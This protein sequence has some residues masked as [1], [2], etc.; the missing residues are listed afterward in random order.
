MYLIPERYCYV[1]FYELG[2]NGKTKNNWS[3]IGERSEK[4]MQFWNII[5]DRR[6]TVWFE[7]VEQIL[8]ECFFSS[9]PININDGWQLFNGC[10]QYRRCATNQPIVILMS[11][12]NGTRKNYIYNDT[13]SNIVYSLLKNPHEW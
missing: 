10:D 4:L 1:L 6:R 13:K 3:A 12:M 8:S 5:S 7:H 2:T 11:I 9:R